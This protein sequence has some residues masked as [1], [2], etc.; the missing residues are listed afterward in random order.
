METS[1]H[2][3]YEY[4]RRRLKQKKNLYLHFIFLFLGCIFL[5]VLHKITND[6]SNSQW[7]I[8]VITIWIFIFSL[9]FIK[10]FITD[11]FMNKNWERNQIDK[12]IDLQQKKIQQLQTKF[13]LETT[14]QKEI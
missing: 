7:H 2:E 13:T 10:V 1:E 9:H 12:L 14:N 3:Q 11:S 4:A 5:F 6:A 8:W